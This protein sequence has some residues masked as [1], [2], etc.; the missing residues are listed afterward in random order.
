ML[1]TLTTI[2]YG[3]FASQMRLWGIRSLAELARITGIPSPRLSSYNSLNSVPRL[4]AALD[5]AQALHTTVE[6]L[7]GTESQKE[8]K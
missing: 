8:E 2:K 7:W 6:E 4:Y 3:I 1:T 5:I